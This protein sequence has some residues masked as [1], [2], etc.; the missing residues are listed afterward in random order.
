MLRVQHLR[1]NLGWTIQD[2]LLNALSKV[3]SC[4]FEIWLSDMTESS[5]WNS[6]EMKLNDCLR[7]IQ[8][9]FWNHHNNGRNE[10]ISHLKKIVRFSQFFEWVLRIGNK[11][12]RVLM[13]NILL[14]DLILKT[15]TKWS[16]F[17]IGCGDSLSGSAANA[18]TIRWK[19]AGRNFRSRDIWKS[20][21]KELKADVISIDKSSEIVITIAEMRRSQM[22]KSLWV[23][24]NSFNEFSEWEKRVCRLWVDMSC[25]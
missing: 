9:M 2:H 8:E 17:T 18:L 5:V 10:D 1:R 16:Y 13:I 24:H 4:Y 6:S 3:R 25:E 22:W 14:T 21:Y 20:F 7:W 15:K 23:S 19:F 11:G 12:V